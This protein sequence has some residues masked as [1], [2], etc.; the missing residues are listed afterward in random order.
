MA[1]PHKCRFVGSEPVAR[2]FKP[3]GVPARDLDTAE[4]RLDELEALR[5][6]DVEGMYHG[7]AA[8]EMGISRATFGRLIQSARNK[9]ADA[10][11]SGKMLTIKGGKVEMIRQRAF[12]CSACEARFEVP[13]GTPRPDACPA[14]GSKHVH[15]D[16]AERGHG[17]TNN[18]G[19]EGHHHGQCHGHG[20]GAG[21][22]HGHGCCGNR[23]EQTAPVAGESNE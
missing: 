15:R 10:L 16:P 6:G 1:R 14:C 11:L 5:L 20:H 7:D 23:E 19:R 18:Q 9:V 22:E 13:C 4:L 2:A 17:C 3:I 8:E 12:L 21:H